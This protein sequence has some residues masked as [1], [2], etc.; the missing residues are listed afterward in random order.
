[1][2]IQYM[3]DK[4]I[5]LIANWKMHG[6]AASVSQFT[7]DMAQLTADLPAWLTVIFCPPTC[8]ISQA[9]SALAAAEA[10]AQQAEN[11]T[12]TLAAAFYIGA[13][14]VHQKQQGA[15]TGNISA[16][17]L[18]DLHCSHTL[19]GHSE[20]RQSRHLSDAQIASQALSAQQAGITPIICIGESA[21]QY[22]AKQTA[23]ILQ[24]QL[25]AL[26]I[27]MQQGACMI[28]YEPLWA[29]GSGKTPAID[30]IA[31]AHMACKQIIAQLSHKQK[32]ARDSALSVLYGGS[33]TAK[34]VKNILEIPSVDGALIGSASITFEGF[35]ALIKAAI[36]Q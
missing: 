7:R 3:E 10:Q 21:A 26:E 30:E 28:A 35:S 1:M 20:D 33:V 5:T 9:V 14:A 22:A 8:Y 17:M 13:Q 36:T 19:I 25:Q 6:T 32:L 31:A 16:E 34:N 29:I 24:N 23:A 4:Q 12:G 15:H 2:H 18:K 11:K 27:P